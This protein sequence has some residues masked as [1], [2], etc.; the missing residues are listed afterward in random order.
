[1]SKLFLPD[2]QET[3]LEVVDSSGQV[4]PITAESYEVS[5]YDLEMI[6]DQPLPA[7]SYRLISSP[8]DGLTDLAGQAVTGAT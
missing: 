2:S 8:T 5:S 3:A 1:M 6:F 4:W 7:G